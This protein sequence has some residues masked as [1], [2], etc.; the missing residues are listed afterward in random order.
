QIDVIFPII[1]LVGGLYGF[2]KGP[3]SL[4]LPFVASF[5]MFPFLMY[6]KPYLFVY[7]KGSENLKIYHLIYYPIVGFLVFALVGMLARTLDH[8][9]KKYIPGGKGLWGF[10]IGIFIS[11]F[12][13]I[14][15]MIFSL[16]LLMK[17][18]PQMIS[19]S[20][21]LSSLALWFQD[22]PEQYGRLEAFL[23][24]DSIKDVISKVKTIRDGEA[25]S[26]EE[27]LN[28]EDQKQS[29]SFELQKQMDL[30][31]ALDVKAL[32]EAT[33]DKRD[34][35]SLKEPAKGSNNQLNLQKQLQKL[36]NF[37][38]SQKQN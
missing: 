16:P 15:L 6:V 5:L 31:N 11:S 37:Q 32:Q 3:F 23:H 7:L 2:L 9:V 22:H 18:S 25:N 19:R 12:V 27:E 29:T 8:K 13:C 36:L 24:I 14:A 10:I 21:T 4:I 35:D 33:Y 28:V 30:N 34:V 17:F 1:I 26:P 38:K 20:W